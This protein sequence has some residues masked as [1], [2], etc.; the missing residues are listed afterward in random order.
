M[1]TKEDSAVDVDDNGIAFVRNDNGS[2]D[3][4]FVGAETGLTLSG[5]LRMVS[6]GT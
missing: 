6:I 1:E 5:C 4:E 3:M 2:I